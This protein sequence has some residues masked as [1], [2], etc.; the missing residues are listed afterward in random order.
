MLHMYVA[1][2]TRFPCQLWF[3][4]VTADGA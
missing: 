4:Y 3:I 2:E 1:S